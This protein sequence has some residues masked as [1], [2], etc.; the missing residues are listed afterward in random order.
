MRLEIL[1]ITYVRNDERW[2]VQSTLN[3][4][5]AELE[6]LR[7]RLRALQYADDVYFITKE[8]PA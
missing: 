8:V 1:Q 2:A 4:D 3:I 5:P 7:A 6:R